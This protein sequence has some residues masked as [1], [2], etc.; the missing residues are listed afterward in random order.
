VN[1][2]RT[3]GTPPH[4]TAHDQPCGRIRVASDIQRT[5]HV[6]LRMAVAASDFSRQRN[7]ATSS[8]RTFPPPRR[9][10]GYRQSYTGVNTGPSAATR[11]SREY[12]A[13]KIRLMADAECS[14][15]KAIQSTPCREPHIVWG[16]ALPELAQL[17]DRDLRVDRILNPRA[18]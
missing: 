15:A 10:A 8:S 13:N 5:V 1:F 16:I 11:C 14:R 2:S 6:L 9:F 7:R 4:T 17:R 18:R 3:S 12:S